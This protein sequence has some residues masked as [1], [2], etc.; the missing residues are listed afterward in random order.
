MSKI[1]YIAKV[2]GLVGKSF[3]NLEE[4]KQASERKLILLK[5]IFAEGSLTSL[6]TSIVVFGSI[7]RKECTTKSDLDWQFLI[8]GQ[9][10]S[11]YQDIPRQIKETLAKYPDEFVDPNAT[12]H[13]GK[14]GFSHD[15]IHFI[16]GEN[17]SNANLSSRMLLILESISIGNTEAYQRILKGIFER[18]L[19]EEVHIAHNGLYKVPRFLLND[20]VRFWRTMAV[21]FARKQR[22]RG[23]EG[24]GIRNIK[25]RMSR[26]LIFVSGLLMVFNCSKEAVGSEKESY[27]RFALQEYL[28]SYTTMTP[29]E[30]IARSIIEYSIDSQI[31]S[32]IFESYDAFLEMLNSEDKRTELSGLKAMT[33]TENKTFKNAIIYCDRFEKALDTLFFETDCYQHITRK[34]AVF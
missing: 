2:E 12:G 22:E 1:D 10:K 21:D 20:I 25:L 8:D 3:S 33:A 17:D 4:A 16:G 31:G 24:W 6:D 27:Q 23:G 9:A 26:K 15:L 28:M 18:Y 7:A 11:T 34:Y 19:E 13:F 30:I 29:L 14:M 5:N 32:D